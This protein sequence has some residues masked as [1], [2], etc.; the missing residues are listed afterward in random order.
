MAEWVE[1]GGPIRRR[2]RGSDMNI[3]AGH[4]S[5]EVL[6]RYSMGALSE[7]QSAPLEEHLLLCE[8]CR[9]R[10]EELDQFTRLMKAA[11]TISSPP[12]VLPEPK[13]LRAHTA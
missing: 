6:E 8:L 12:A 4:L 1:I 3:R 13:R 10:L 11:L 2:E 7:P 9:T 5:D